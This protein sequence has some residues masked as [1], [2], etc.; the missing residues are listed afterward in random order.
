MSI[1]YNTNGTTTVPDALRIDYVPGCTGKIGHPTRAEAKK[2][3]LQWRE[4]GPRSKF[5]KMYNKTRQRI[6][7]LQASVYHCDNCGQ[8]HWGNAPPKE[9]GR[10]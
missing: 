9:R 8:F 10:K 1:T 5:A 3:M 2:A 6:G 4:H 7:E